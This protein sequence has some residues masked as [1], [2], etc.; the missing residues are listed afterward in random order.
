MKMNGTCQKGASRAKPYTYAK[1]T[2]PRTLL[3]Q[4]SSNRVGKSVSMPSCPMNL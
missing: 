4:R 3:R 1:K 2:F